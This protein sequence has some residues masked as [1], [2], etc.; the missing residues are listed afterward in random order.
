LHIA[1]ELGGRRR[2]ECDIDL[3]T[4]AV[5]GARIDGREHQIA[6]RVECQSAHLL[7]G[8]M[9]VERLRVHL[10]P[11]VEEPILGAERIRDELFRLVGIGAFR[12][13]KASGGSPVATVL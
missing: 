11:I 3:R 6:D 9:P 5:G 2:P 13:A 1:V 7:V 8:V 12:E 10:Q 4:F